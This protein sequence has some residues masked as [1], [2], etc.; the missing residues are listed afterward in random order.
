MS[1]LLDGLRACEEK[2]TA[3]LRERIVG[4]GSP[5]VPALIDLLLED[6]DDDDS[7][8]DDGG[9][10]GSIHAVDLL[11]SRGIV[12]CR[13]KHPSA[14]K[15]LER[16]RIAFA[17][18]DQDAMGLDLQRRKRRGCSTPVGHNRHKFSRSITSLS[19]LPAPPLQVTRASFG[20][21]E[22]GESRGK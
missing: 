11:L 5:I 10:W 15:S 20:I 8:D 7:E 21:A 14:R 3:S 4:E 2:L 12:A 16:Y 19:E 1:A 17:M 6:E 22:Q 13:R 18:P 9:G